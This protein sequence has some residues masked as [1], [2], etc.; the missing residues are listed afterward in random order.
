MEGGTVKCHRCSDWTYS[1]HNHK[2]KGQK[3]RYDPLFSGRVIFINLM[4]V[5]LIKVIPVYHQGGGIRHIR[6]CVH[7]RPVREGGDGVDSHLT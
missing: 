7:T 6:P 2:G 5:P 4:R 1:P 3:L